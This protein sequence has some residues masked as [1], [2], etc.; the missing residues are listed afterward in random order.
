M[1]RPGWP[2]NAAG[3]EASTLPSPSPLNEKMSCQLPFRVGLR[4]ASTLKM[5][6]P[7]SVSILP[8]AATLQRLPP[9]RS[10]PTAL[11]T[12]LFWLAT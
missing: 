5:S 10:M 4:L 12:Q 8:S 11:R 2:L 7:A 6:W 3:T 9:V 1:N